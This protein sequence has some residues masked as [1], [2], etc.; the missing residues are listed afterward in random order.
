MNVLGKQRNDGRLWH[1]REA[2]RGNRGQHSRLAAEG[3]HYCFAGTAGLHDSGN[4][5]MCGLGKVTLR[6]HL[7]TEI[8]QR[9]DSFQQTTKVIFLHCHFKGVSRN[10]R[11]KKGNTR[12][13][14]R[15]D[16]HCWLLWC[17]ET[18]LEMRSEIEERVHNQQTPGRLC[19]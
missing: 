9:F 17:G 11:R 1:E 15:C 14:P 10:V 12:K 16:E 6:R 5:G 18:L 19:G 8:G 3:E 7:R 4:H 13:Y 2:S